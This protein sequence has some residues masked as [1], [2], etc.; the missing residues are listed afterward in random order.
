MP[1]KSPARK[2][3][4]KRPKANAKKPAAKRAGTAGKAEGDAPVRA[5]IAS[6]PSWQREIGER[7]D[8]LVAK[9][10]PAVKRAVK[11][12]VPFYGLEGRGWFASFG[13]FS[14]HVKINFFKGTA[15]KP[16]PPSGEGKD[17]RAID[18]RSVAE[19]E[20]APIASWVKQAAKLPG[21]GK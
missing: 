13:A 2:T 8:A 3:A 14:K 16:V 10:V 11:W 9:E 18:L 19:F 15:L 5:Y 17:L 7:F 20:A 6:L 12:S 1:A 4:K 21:W